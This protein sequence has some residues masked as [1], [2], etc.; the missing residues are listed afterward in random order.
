MDKLNFILFVCCIL[1]GWLLISLFE[2][3]REASK[4]IAARE[5]WGKTKGGVKPM[6]QWPKLA[7]RSFLLLIIGLLLIYSIP[8][9]AADIKKFLIKG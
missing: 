7:I 9:I 2:I 5:E 4:I 1:G 8:Y 6:V 3:N